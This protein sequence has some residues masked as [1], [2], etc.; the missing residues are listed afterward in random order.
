MASLS[1]C[2]VCWRVYACCIHIHTHTSVGHGEPW[3]HH[4]SCLL[5]LRNFQNNM[6]Q[7]TSQ[8]ST[9][10]LL[11]TPTPIFSFPSLPHS[12]SFSFSFSSSL[13]VPTHSD[14]RH[15]LV[16]KV[17]PCNERCMLPAS[18]CLNQQPALCN[19]ALLKF[20]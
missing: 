15:V 11:H 8:R 2:L 4:R 12:T 7:A 3:Y 14:L 18:K 19:I 16:Y 1:V 9:H 5:H 10:A 6:S 13:T 17:P 20:A